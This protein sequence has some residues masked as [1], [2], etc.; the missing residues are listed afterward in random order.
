MIKILRR[1]IITDYPRG[2]NLIISF[3]Y[4]GGKENQAREDMQKT[5][6]DVGMMH[7][8]MEERAMLKEYMYPLKAGKGKRIKVKAFQGH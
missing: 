7:F 2:S 8:L 1:E 5:E 4:L 6:V 3:R